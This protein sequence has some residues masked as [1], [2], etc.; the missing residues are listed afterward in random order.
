MNKTFI[1]GNG[2]LYQSLGSLEQLV[3]DLINIKSL[4][5]DNSNSVT[6]VLR[7]INDNWE[8]PEGLD[9]QSINDSLNMCI[10]KL[11]VDFIPLMENFI[12]AIINLIEETRRNSGNTI[13][14]N[15]L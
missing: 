5:A 4:I 2:D 11:D 10:E 7:K 14:G 8:N 12:S 13:S 3:E 6:Y 9:L 1:I 15:A